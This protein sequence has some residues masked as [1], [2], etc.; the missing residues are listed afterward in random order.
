VRNSMI[1]TDKVNL[2]FTEP[3]PIIIIIIIIII[4]SRDLIGFRKART[5]KIVP[6]DL[7]QY[8]LLYYSQISIFYKNKAEKFCILQ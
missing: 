1:T 7:P 4:M 5:P 3:L 2:C 6:T 8:S